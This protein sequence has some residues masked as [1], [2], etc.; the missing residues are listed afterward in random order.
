MKASS[1]GFQ[2][3]V[4]FVLAGMIWGLQMAISGDHV[5]LPAHAHLN[6]L[7]FVALFLFSIYYHL[8]PALDRSRAA[9]VQVSVWIV[10]TIV[11]AIGVGLVHTGHA[12]G[13]PFAAIGSLVVFAAMLMFGW[14]VYRCE[15]GVTG[16]RTV[17]VPAE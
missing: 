9:V 8:H 5:A 2:A 13:D 10:G 16:E 7:G 3:A 12:V 4:V 14:L 6:L 11:M 1:F 17:V 15:R